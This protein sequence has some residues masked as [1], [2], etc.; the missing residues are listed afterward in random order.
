[1]RFV[2]ITQNDAQRHLSRL[3]A[4]PVNAGLLCEVACRVPYQHYKTWSAL[5]TLLSEC[6]RN[7]SCSVPECRRMNVY[8]QGMLSTAS[9][10]TAEYH[11]V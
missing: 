8:E 5:S 3:E 9:T 4:Q 6:C 2:Q 11:V 7:V 10:M 1:M